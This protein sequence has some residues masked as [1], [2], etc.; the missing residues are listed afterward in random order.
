MTT[1]RSSRRPSY[2]R[3]RCRRSPA[4]RRARSTGGAPA[5]SGRRASCRGAPLEWGAAVR[6]FHELGGERSVAVGAEDAARDRALVDLGELGV[7]R[8]ELCAAHA[9]VLGGG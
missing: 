2:R 3:R 4:R 6:A 5:R 8:L 9:V 1:I 7:E